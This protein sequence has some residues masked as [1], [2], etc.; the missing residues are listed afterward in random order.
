MLQ[1]AFQLGSS[2]DVGFHFLKKGGRGKFAVDRLAGTGP[3]NQ[4]VHSPPHPDQLPIPTRFAR[5][6]SLPRLGTDIGR[7]AIL[8]IAFNGEN[9][10][11]D[12]AWAQ[13]LGDRLAVWVDHHDQEI[14]KQLQD[15]ERFHLVPRAE[16]PACP[17][18][19][20]R[21]LVRACGPVDLL[22]CHGDTDGVLSAA[23]WMVLASDLEVPEWLDAD[24]I[25]ADTRRG[26]FSPQG[27]R[28]D[29][30]IRTAGG[31]NRTRRCV[32]AAVLAEALGVP[33]AM[34]V[35][36]HLEQALAEWKRLLFHTEGVLKS[37]VT[38]NDYDESIGLIDLRRYQPNFRLDVTELMLRMQAQHDWVVVLG[39]AAGGG[40]K[41]VVSTDPTR[42][43]FDVRQEFDLQGFAPF[44]AHVPATKLLQRLPSPSLAARLR[45]L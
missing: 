6:G 33:E 40:L 17:P 44:R 5:P 27:A 39:R 8:D 10:Q 13:A 14:W 4:V 26:E 41:I 3:H 32:I 16:A 37:A 31:R 2:I 24:S 45:G 35:R 11:A 38:L 28:L 18:L 12:L 23:K 42:T 21:E 22:L 25:V 7:V 15:E 30:A 36:L 19:V 20:T 29:A 43:G 1:A 34:E 9:P